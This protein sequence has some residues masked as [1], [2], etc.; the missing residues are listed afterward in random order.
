MPLLLP[1]APA[2]PPLP[3]PAPPPYCCFLQQHL[4]PP[5]L[6]DP[7]GCFTPA[8]SISAALTVWLRFPCPH[9]T[10]AGKPETD[11]SLHNGHHV[12]PTT[13]PSMAPLIRLLHLL[14]PPATARQKLIYSPVATFPPIEYR[15]TKKKVPA[16]LQLIEK[17]ISPV[18]LAGSFLS[19]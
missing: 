11:D 19:T 15:L 9:H 8:G 2:A 13:L 5:P 14:S 10:P 7:L 6:Q 12:L 1:P 17:G 18:Y 16:L 3:S 4:L